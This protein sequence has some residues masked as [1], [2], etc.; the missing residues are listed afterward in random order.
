MKVNPYLNPAHII[1]EKNG[2][3]IIVEKIAIIGKK[4]RK[5][6]IAQQKTGKF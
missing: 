5:Q 6:M 2:K 3:Q 4:T 1:L